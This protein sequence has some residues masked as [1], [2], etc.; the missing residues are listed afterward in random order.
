VLVIFL[1]VEWMQK[2]LNI[3]FMTVCGGITGIALV[4]CSRSCNRRTTFHLYTYAAAASSSRVIIV[5]G[6][7]SEMGMGTW[8]DSSDVGSNSNGFVFYSNL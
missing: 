4:S 7:G 8:G 6:M 5:V 2:W 3:V 1:C